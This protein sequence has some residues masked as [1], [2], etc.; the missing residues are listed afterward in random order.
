MKFFRLFFSRSFLCF[1]IIRSSYFSI[2]L[3]FILTKC[4]SLEFLFVSL[5]HLDDVWKVEFCL[6]EVIQ[7]TMNYPLEHF[8]FIKNFFSLYFWIIRCFRN[9]GNTFQLFSSR[10]SLHIKIVLSSR[11]NWEYLPC[12]IFSE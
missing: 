12:D 1:I 5:F 2:R 10:F 4:W 11:W 9:E 8:Y 3:F 7:G 6:N